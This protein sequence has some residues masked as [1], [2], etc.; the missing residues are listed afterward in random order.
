MHSYF[1]ETGRTLDCRIKEQKQSREKQDKAN[2][3]S[4]YHIETKHRINWEGATCVDLNDFQDKRM[5]LESWFTKCDGSTRGI[6]WQI[7]YERRPPCF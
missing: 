6:C 1:G 4:I 3:I 2:R 7:A 5:F